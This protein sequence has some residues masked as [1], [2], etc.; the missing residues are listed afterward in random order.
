[1]AFVHMHALIQS[2]PYLSGGR[3]MY[4]WNG[5]RSDLFKGEDN[6][7]LCTKHTGHKMSA[8]PIF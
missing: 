8:S 1:M 2:G 6:L 3:Y 4:N 5:M 7:L